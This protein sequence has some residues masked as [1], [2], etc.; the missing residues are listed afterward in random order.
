M[1]GQGEEDV[2][3]VVAHAAQDGE[4]VHVAERSIFEVSDHQANAIGPRQD[5][6][7]MTVTDPPQS[8]DSHPQTVIGGPSP[9][10]AP[11]RA[12]R[13]QWSPSGRPG[14]EGPSGER[15]QQSSS[16]G[17]VDVPSQGETLPHTL[18]KTWATAIF[19]MCQVNDVVGVAAVSEAGMLIIRHS[20]SKRPRERQFYYVFSHTFVQ[21]HFALI[22]TLVST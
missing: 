15:L 18:R 4:V 6:L 16:F 9:T 3:A 2:A 14:Q 22:S 12:Q 19:E 11:H 10:G 5:T 7:Q 20:P 1:G 21:R 13:S 17:G 8:D